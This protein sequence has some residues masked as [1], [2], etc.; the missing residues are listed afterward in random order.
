MTDKIVVKQ[1]DVVF[2]KQNE[3]ERSIVAIASVEKVDRDNDLLDLQSLNIKDFK[4]NGV[5]LWAH[6]SHLPPIAKA[7]SVKVVDKELKMKI[8]FPEPEVSSFSDT[9]YK[10]VKAGYINTLSV[11]F[12][13]DWN[14][15]NTVYDKKRG[16]YTFK[17]A[18]LLE[19][20]LVNIPSNSGAQIIS[21]SL[22]TAVTNGIIDEVE[23]TDFVETLKEYG[24]DLSK[25]ETPPVIEVKIDGAGEQ[26]SSGSDNEIAINSLNKK[27]KQ[28]E[29]KIED[30]SK[31]IKND[32]KE[33][34]NIHKSDEF[35]KELLESVGLEPK[36]DSNSV[37]T[38]VDEILSD[39]E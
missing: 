16:G 34:E 26:N 8:Q 13:P 35:F 21:R 39:K 6:D 9:I 29:D 24:I 5:I 36:A 12:K 38:F 19:T 22:N 25:K 7:T 31:M 32:T 1:T 11:A 3:E 30:I 15:P 27:I 20:S 37:E 10:L 18:T 28:L 4:K 17:N 33:S 14:E 2:K 23:K